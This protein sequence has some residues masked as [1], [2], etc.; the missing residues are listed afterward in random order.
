MYVCRIFAYRQS[1]NAN[2][3]SAV[4]L[5]DIHIWPPKRP[6]NYKYVFYYCSIPIEL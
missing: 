1:S 2:I 4:T 3:K 6:V 5:N